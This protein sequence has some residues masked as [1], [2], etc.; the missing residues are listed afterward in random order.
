MQQLYELLG[1]E[2][3]RG[4]H[5]MEEFVENPRSSAF[6][7]GLQIDSI[8]SLIHLDGQYL[9]LIGLLLQSV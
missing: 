6:N 8:F 4:F 7:E 3:S 5:C 9:Y 1:A 2:S